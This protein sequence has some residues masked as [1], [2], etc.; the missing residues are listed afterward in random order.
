[1]VVPPIGSLDRFSAWPGE[2]IRV[3]AA[4]MLP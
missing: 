2:N 4:A 1:M 3:I